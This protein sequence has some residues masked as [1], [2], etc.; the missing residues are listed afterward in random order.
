MLCKSR[1][2]LERKGKLNIICDFTFS[3]FPEAI[4]QNLM[5]LFIVDD[6]EVQGTCSM[7]Q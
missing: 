5:R 7:I 3:E 2:Q 4:I 1:Y 6:V